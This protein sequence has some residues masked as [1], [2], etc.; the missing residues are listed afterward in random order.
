MRLVETHIEVADVE[1]AVEFYA[2]LLPHRKVVRWSDGSAAAIV[3][4]DGGAFGLWSI[5]KEGLHG[6]RGGEHQHFAFQIEPGEYD[7]YKVKL[8]SLGVKPIEHEWNNG[9]RSIYFF[10][11]DG[12]QGEFM[13]TD[14]IGL[15]G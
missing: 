6:G 15:Q 3:L 1:R 8:E 13:T 11:A 9:G 2:A 5:G 14:W 12:H 7:E 4:E 10:D